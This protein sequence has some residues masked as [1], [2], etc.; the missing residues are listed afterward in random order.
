MNTVLQSP[1][2]REREKAELRTRILDAARELFFQNGYEAVTMRE[3]ARR[4]DYTATALYYHFPD[5]RSLLLE[6]CQ[7]D[8]QVLARSLKKLGRSSDPVERLRQMGLAYVSFGHDH[9]QHYRLMFMTPEA[10][11][12]PAPQADPD[13]LPPD[14]EAYSFLRQ[15]VEEAIETGRFQPD[16]TDVDAVAQALWAGMHGLVALHLTKAEDDWIQ[17][18]PAK[19]TVRLMVDLLLRGLLR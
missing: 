13:Q 14:R 12:C 2:R 3:V 15:A 1:N 4:I 19:K 18:R 17:W 10:H 7:Q 8:F 11:P 9:P 5:K 16:I 6:L